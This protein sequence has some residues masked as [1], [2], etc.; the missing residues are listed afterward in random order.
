MCCSYNLPNDCFDAGETKPTKAKKAKTT[1]KRSHREAGME[2][3]H[4]RK[5]EPVGAL[6]VKIQQLFDREEA[7]IETL[8]L[9]CFEHTGCSL[10][11]CLHVAGGR[12]TELRKAPPLGERRGSGNSRRLSSAP[13]CSLSV[14][15]LV[16]VAVRTDA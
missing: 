14:D 7:S 15:R 10:I 8:G 2:V 6:P 4:G 3:S 16:E 13:R 9:G 12:I 1:K 11:Q 5:P